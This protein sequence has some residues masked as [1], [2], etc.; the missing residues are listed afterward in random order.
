MP[1]VPL[2]GAST[3]FL[4]SWAC[5]A[6]TSAAARS[7]RAAASSN[8]D[9]AMVR[10]RTSFAV[11]SN[12]TSA[13]RC[14]ARSPL[15]TAVSTDDSRV[16]SASP[17]LTIWPESKFKAVTIPGASLV[18]KVFCTAVRLPVPLMMRGQDLRV[19]VVT[20]TWVGGGGVENFAAISRIWRCLVSAR[21][22]KIAPATSIIKRN[23]RSMLMA[24]GLVPGG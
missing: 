10:S 23:L 2:N 21:P 11:R 4:A 7:R 5:C 24:L 1:K 12:C 13:R 6:P 3:V 14:S 15:S 19:T 16:T 20:A 9:C 17:L 18:T 22:P 8:C